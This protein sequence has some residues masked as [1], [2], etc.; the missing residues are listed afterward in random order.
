[1]IPSLPIPQ[2]IWVVRSDRELSRDLDNSCESRRLSFQVSK[3]EL[4]CKSHLND[5]KGPAH[6]FKPKNL[7][8]LT[9]F[10]RILESHHITCLCG[11]R[12]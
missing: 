6:L 5:H 1:M 2:S 8:W 11:V 12:F 9:Y 10:K 3:S 4:K 7:Q